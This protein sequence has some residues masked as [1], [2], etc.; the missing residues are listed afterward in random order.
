MANHYFINALLVTTFWMVALLTLRRSA[1]SRLSNPSNSLR[2]VVFLDMF[3]GGQWEL[4]DDDDDDDKGLRS[5]KNILN[6]V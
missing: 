2:G 5:R 4:D 1:G 3:D 6:Q